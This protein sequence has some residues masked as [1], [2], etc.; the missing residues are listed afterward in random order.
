[1][2]SREN[3]DTMVMDHFEALVKQK[4]GTMPIGRPGPQTRQ[5]QNVE[6][7]MSLGPA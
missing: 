5:R 3:P 1:M 7:D 6:A 2:W 4:V